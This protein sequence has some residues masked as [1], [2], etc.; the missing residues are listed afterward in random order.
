MLDYSWCK[1]FQMKLLLKLPHSRGG[2]IG[3]NFYSKSHICCTISVLSI[4]LI[5]SRVKHK[6]EVQKPKILKIVKNVRKKWRRMGLEEDIVSASD[7]QV[8]FS[9]KTMFEQF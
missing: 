6:L 4:I 8:F 7:S 3:G 2:D 1:M 9:T 5:S